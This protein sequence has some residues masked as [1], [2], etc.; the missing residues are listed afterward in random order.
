MWEA[1]KTVFFRLDAERAHRMTVRS[2][3][4]LAAVGGTKALRVLS[5]ASSSPSQETEVFGLRFRNRVGLAAGFDKDGEL[6]DL[7]PHLGFGFA[8][9]GT[10]TPRPQPGNPAPRLFRDPARKALFNR[11]GFNNAGMDAVADRISRA[12]PGLPAGFRVGINLGKNRDTPL[13]DAHHDYAACARKLG[14]LSDYS[15]VN[16]SSPNTPGLR[17]LQSPEALKR[18][19]GA[20]RDAMERA[21]RCP[22]LLLKLSPELGPEGMDAL[23]AVEG[24]LGLAGWVLTNTVAGEWPLKGGEKISGGWS[25]EPAR[26]PARHALMEL[27]ERSKLPI[28]SVGGIMDEGEGRMRIAL[29]ADLLQVYTGWVYQGPR[30]PGKIAQNTV[31]S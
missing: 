22:P 18:I 19:C 23:A 12:R 24:E 31:S 29:G 26:L 25:G 14:P 20:S 10:V 2:L 17:S 16:V 6:L 28:I 21:G 7:L 27:R 5:G 30:F 9:I 3:R 8:E 15:V 11:M 13:E 4:L 1:A